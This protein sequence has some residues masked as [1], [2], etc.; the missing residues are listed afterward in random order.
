AY[1]PGPDLPT[2]GTIVGL[3]GIR[4]AYATGRGS[5]KTRAKVSIE[6]LSARRSGLV[7]TELPYLVGPEKVI[8]KIKDGVTSKKITGISDV[9]DLTDRKNGLRLVIGI[10][11]G[12]SPEAVLEQLYRLT[13]LEDGFSINNVALV[14][15]RP[16]TLGL[17]ELLRGY[18]DQD[19]KSTR[20]N[21]SHVKNSYA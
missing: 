8:E 16:Q 11:T 5:F 13:P 9:T 2:G 12:F 17:R 18:L 20:L 3:D 6:Q 4:D 7:V 10:K 19:R 21:S 15:G 14:E 1:V